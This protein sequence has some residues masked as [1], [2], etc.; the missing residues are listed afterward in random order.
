MQVSTVTTALVQDVQTR[1]YLL[2]PAAPVHH[3]TA[4]AAAEGA[5]RQVSLTVLSEE[6][7]RSEVE[8]LH[9]R[10]LRSVLHD[11]GGEVK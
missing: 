6:R 5:L 4:L 1:Q 11:D 2:A 8:L 3:L 7:D 10:Q 9:A